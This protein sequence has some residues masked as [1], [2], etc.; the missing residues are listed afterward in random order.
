MKHL[1]EYPE[2]LKRH[3]SCS[4]I[5]LLTQISKLKENIEEVFSRA[6]FKTA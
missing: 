1:L 4:E 2:L 3:H 5:Q 6:S